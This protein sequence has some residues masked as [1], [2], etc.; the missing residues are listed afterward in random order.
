MQHFPFLHAEKMVL[1][2]GQ[3]VNDTSVSMTLM[4]SNW[5]IWSPRNLFLGSRFPLYQQPTCS[6][7]LFLHAD[8][9]EREATVDSKVEG[10]MTLHW[11]STWTIL[12]QFFQCPL[13]HLS[14]HFLYFL[15]FTQN[16]MD[17]NYK[18]SLFPISVVG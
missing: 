2:N 4:H 17:Y 3:E 11:H 16:E 8:C 5:T 12:S 18:S 13:P 14:K 6:I 9:R 1:F 10:C 15:L 7:S